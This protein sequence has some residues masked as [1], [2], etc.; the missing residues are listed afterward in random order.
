[1]TIIEANVQQHALR[2]LNRISVLFPYKW[3]TVTI[4]KEQ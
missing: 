1:M 2:H 3:N 4:F